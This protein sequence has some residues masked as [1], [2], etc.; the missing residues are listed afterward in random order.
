MVVRMLL[1]VKFYIVVVLA[2]NGCVFLHYTRSAAGYAYNAVDVKFLKSAAEFRSSYFSE[3]IAAKNVFMGVFEDECFSELLDCHVFLA[4][5]RIGSLAVEVAIISAAVFPVRSSSCIEIFF[6]RH[7]DDVFEPYSSTTETDTQAL[8]EWMKA[9]LQFSVQ[10]KNKLSFDV[11]VGTS[12][13]SL[14]VVPALSDALVA[15]RLGDNVMFQLSNDVYSVFDF[16][17]INLPT[18]T[19]QLSNVF[20]LCNISHDAIEYYTSLNN[21]Y[22]VI[23][24]IKS[25]Y[26][27]MRISAVKGIAQSMLLRKTNNYLQPKLVPKVSRSELGFSLV[28]LPENIYEMLLGWYHEKLSGQVL[29]YYGGDVINQLDV[30]TFM[31]PLNQL[32]SYTLAYE[33][34]SIMQDWYAGDDLL[35]FSNSYGFR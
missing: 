16:M 17:M 34:H 30:P 12:T 14:G 19:L 1:V 6:Y 10:L 33:L 24:E 5:Q 7:G 29:E 23:Q 22:A 32:E 8:M 21:D 26:D 25:N 3:D 9:A 28:R 4:A 18:Y 13:S 35:K 11:V 2:I 15:G 20:D 31:A 27:I